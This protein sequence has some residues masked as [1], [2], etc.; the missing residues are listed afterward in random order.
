M[1][2]QPERPWCSLLRSTIEISGGDP[3]FVSCSVIRPVDTTDLLTS[4][5]RNSFKIKDSGSLHTNVSTLTN[6]HACLKKRQTNKQETAH[7]PWPFFSRQPLSRLTFVKG[8]CLQT[9]LSDFNLFI[10]FLYLFHHHI[11]S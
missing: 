9:S 6:E 10:F 3:S 11:H 4:E 2:Q 8:V 1:S 7:Y 5:N